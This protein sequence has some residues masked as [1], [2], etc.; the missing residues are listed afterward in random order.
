VR[1]IGISRLSVGI[2]E[3]RRSPLVM[4]FKHGFILGVVGGY[5]GRSS[6]ESIWGGEEALFERGTEFGSEFGK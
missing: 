5:G 6:E 1:N 4:G 2:L 3:V